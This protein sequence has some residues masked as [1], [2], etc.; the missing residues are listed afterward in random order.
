MVGSG[1]AISELIVTGAP[2]NNGTY[3]VTGGLSCPSEI[4]GPLTCG[5]LAFTTGAGNQ[6]GTSAGVNIFAGGGSITVT[7][8]VETLGLVPIATGNLATGSFTGAV[9]TASS[10]IGNGID[11]K[12][13]TLLNY[14]GITN[15]DFTFAQVTLDMGVVNPNSAFSTTVNTA[16]FENSETPEPR[17]TAGLLLVGLVGGLFAARRFRVQQ[18]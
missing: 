4:V 17:W 11:V 7:G 3:I 8:T 2:V 1:I 6:T 10:S 9:A 12:N 13:Q 15:P 14:L 5:T 18:S 16:S